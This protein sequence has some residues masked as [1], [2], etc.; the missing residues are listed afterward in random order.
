MWATDENSSHSA[1]SLSSS[2]VSPA[3]PP[4][5]L[6][7]NTL[8]CGSQKCSQACLCIS[9]RLFPLHSLLRLHFSS[10]ALPSPPSPWKSSSDI[11]STLTPSVCPASWP[12]PQ[13]LELQS[14]LT[15]YKGLFTHPYLPPNKAL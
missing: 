7:S 3:T 14:A 8:F 12:F 6:Y 10:P 5:P 9:P 4:L 13:H 11:T 1:R 2:P 15:N